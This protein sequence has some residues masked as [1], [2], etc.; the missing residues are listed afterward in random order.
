MK[1]FIQYI[2]ES[3]SIGKGSP[4]ALAK[5][6][7]GEKPTEPT[8]PKTKVKP[9]S[10][11]DIGHYSKAKDMKEVDLYHVG[12]KSGY[13]EINHY[14]HHKESNQRRAKAGWDGKVTPN[15]ANHGT[16]EKTNSDEHFAQGRIDHKLKKYTVN[17]SN[18]KMEE[19]ARKHM[20]KHYPEYSEH[21]ISN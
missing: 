1:S 19:Q 3:A 2:I 4:W 16:W 18:S 20:D 10:V 12:A 9:S 14:T 6:S 8:T 5:G 11:Y 21:H 13:G 15:N 7:V 17:G